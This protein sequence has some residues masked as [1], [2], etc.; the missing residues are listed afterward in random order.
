MIT[1]WND[2]E[3]IEQILYMIAIPSTLVLIVQLVLLL[4]GF[5]EAQDAIN[6]SDT[7]GLNFE[8]VDG[9][10]DFD[11]TDLADS[12]ELPTAAGSDSGALH[13]FTFQTVIVFLSI[14]SW[15]AIVL[16]RFRMAIPLAVA[17]GWA[18]GFLAMLG[19]AKIMQLSAKLQ[20]SG[21]L[22][23]NNALGEI[24]SVYL[25]IPASMNGVGKVHVAV[26]GQLSEFDAMTENDAMLKTGESVRVTDVLGDKLI[27]EK[28]I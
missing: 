11:L 27:V 12:D 23:L 9:E 18:L 8:S 6:P 13:L 28:V 26:Q 19:I 5:G 7:S 20:S 4:I 15:S 14:L 10:A 17:I 1:W 22:D 16:I 3:L 25:T 2:L 24:G 21:T